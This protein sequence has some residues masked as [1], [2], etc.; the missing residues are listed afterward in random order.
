MATKQNLKVLTELAAIDSDYHNGVVE[1]IPGLTYSQT[2]LLRMIE[3]YSNSRYLESQKDA[4]GKDKP[5]YQILNGIVTVENAGKDIDTKDITAVSDNGQYDRS[6]VMSKDIYE[7]MKEV[8][9]GKT[10]NEMIETHSR[11]GGVLVKK[12]IEKDKDGQ[13]QLYLR[14]EVWKNM[15][16]DQIDIRKGAKIAKHFMLPSELLEKKDVWENVPE[17]MKL[18]KKETNKDGST[19]SRRITVH[20]VRN[21]FPRSF[22]KQSQCEDFTEE[23][24][25]DYS[26]QLYYIAGKI[27]SKQIILYAEDDTEDVH[28]YCARKEKAG[29]GLGIG[30]FEEGEEAQVWTNDAVQKQTRAFDIVSR[31]IGQS[32]SKKLK[33]RN[34]L[35]EVDNGTILEHEDGKPITAVPLVPP[36]GMAQFENLIVQWFSQFEHATSAYA[37][38][39]GE[40]T[41]KNFR[42]QS[43]MLQ[44]SQSVFQGLQEDLGLF[45]SEM[46]NDWVLPFLAKKINKAHLLSHEFT[47]EELKEIDRN[48]STNRANQLA[49]EKVLAGTLVTQEDYEKWLSDN[50]A[51]IKQTKSQRFLEIPK[52]YYKNIDAK[53]TVNVT[54]E[55]AN[56]ALIL[57]ALTNIMKLYASNPAIA[58]DPVLMQLFMKIVELSGANIS[59]ISLMSA[60]Q[61]QAAQAAKAQGNNANKISESINFKDLPPDGQTQMAAQAGIKLGGEPDPNAQPDQ[62]GGAPTPQVKD[63]SLS[64]TGGQ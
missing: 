8:L 58:Q 54:G 17:A 49:K 32:A 22:Y 20:E 52:D 51:L 31:A 6:F 18:A 41:T 29:R 60:I 50:D 40:T 61:E 13:D 23:D 62:G 38:Q 7:W 21:Y 45:I 55:Q 30:V 35:T 24:E 43:L 10:L 15:V 39:R 9:F 12:C 33:G 46:F 2:K 63:L 4:Q 53:I 19:T 28:K 47:I 26:Y 44:Q 5:F 57:E 11:Y 37:T 64:A 59:P 3:F 16:T 1:I 48:F 34:M 36:G 14:V 42:L 27:G 56:K 25:M